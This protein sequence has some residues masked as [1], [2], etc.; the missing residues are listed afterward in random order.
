M[1]QEWWSNIRP[2]KIERVALD[3]QPEVVFDL[4]VNS[5]GLHWR[6]E[7]EVVNIPWSSVTS[8]NFKVAETRDGDSYESLGW[9]LGPASP[10][11]FALLR[12]LQ[13]RRSASTLVVQHR[14]P[15]GLV[16]LRVS[17]Q[18]NVLWQVLKPAFKRAQKLAKG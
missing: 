5:E 14:D 6:S 1:T 2:T 16:T 3:S 7:F 15:Q 9:V 18:S 8:V 13:R 4:Y 12:K 10:A 11:F 17:R